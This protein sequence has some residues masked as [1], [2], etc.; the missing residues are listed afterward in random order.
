[1]NIICKTLKLQVMKKFLLIVFGGI[2][3]GLFVMLINNNVKP[4]LKLSPAVYTEQLPIQFASNSMFRPEMAEDFT[5]AAEQTINSVVHIHTEFQQRYNNPF[6]D[7]YRYFYGYEPRPLTGSGSGVIITEDGYIVTN[8]HVIDRASKISVT[9]NDKRTYEATVV[10]TDPTTDLAL[11][12]I[13]EKQL[14]FIKF[15]NSDAVKVGEWVLA[16][17]NPFNLT[18][19]VTAGIVSAKGRSLHILGGGTSIESF[20]QTDAAVNPGNSG[21]ALV[22]TQG[23]LIGINAAIASN[24]GSYAGYSFAIPVSIVKKVVVDIIELGDVHRAYLGVSIR[25]INAELAS[26]I[27]LSDMKGVYVENLI[28]GGAAEKSGIRSGDVILN[29]GGNPVNNVPE[30]REIVA[31]FRPGDEVAMLVRRDGKEKELKLTLLNAEGESRIAKPAETRVAKMLGA[32]FQELSDN[33]KRKLG[34]R[35]G[36]K[37]NNLENGKLKSAGIRE[38]F[39]ITRIDNTNV[40]SVNEL[41]SLLNS[42]KGGILIEGIYP[43]GLRAYYGFGL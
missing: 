26:Q 41:L 13:T 2:I 39:I 34:I 10:G 3:G 15:G 43:N 36:V 24:T 29:I 9:L 11:L 23:E 30:L 1:M 6:Q 8:N 37:I 21:G 42:K 7:F 27:S 18:S 22:N 33:D 35:S 5:F 38:G 12:Q 32:S 20:I 16:V 17:G 25:D 4:E 40:N 28:Q 14:P 31:R 19:T